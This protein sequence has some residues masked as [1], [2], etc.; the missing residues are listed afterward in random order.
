[1]KKFN[2]KPLLFLGFIAIVFLVL[3]IALPK[4]YVNEE[5]IHLEVEA[6]ETYDPKELFKEYIYPSTKMFIKT[7][8]GWKET[9]LD[10]ELRVEDETFVKLLSKDTVLKS[11]EITFELVGVDTT[12]PQITLH[13]E[14][15]QIEGG[16]NLKNHIDFEVMDKRF[17]AYNLELKKPDVDFIAMEIGTFQYTITAT[18]LSGNESSLT[19]D[20]EVIPYTISQEEAERNDLWVNKARRFAEDFEPE[21]FDIPE[22]YY[23]PHD[24]M[25]F[26]LREEALEDYIAMVDTLKEETGLWMY[27]RNA[28]RP[29][30]QQ[31]TIYNNYVAQDGEE[32]ANRYSARP[33]H[34]EHQSGL[35]MDVRT[36]EYNYDDFGKSEAYTWVKDNAHRFGYIIRYPEGKEEI[37]KYM[38]E[39]WH[40]RYVGEEIA[41]YLYKNDLTF[42][43][44]KIQNKT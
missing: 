16:S 39:A 11:K 37:T 32:E 8:L 7:N 30:Q 26:M 20:F 29:Y 33:G 44:Y 12:P 23:Y 36:D 41:T 43:E 17:G 14:D 9:S 3:Y 2:M 1:M 25:Y 38:P 40:L 24:G 18:D 35:T 10:T 22:G 15:I 19:F 5:S 42:D 13:S 21:M 6:Y 4:V 28:Y 34:S 31:K 27:V